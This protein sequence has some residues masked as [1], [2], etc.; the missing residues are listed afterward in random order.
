M[1]VSEASSS[2]STNPNPSMSSRSWRLRVV[3]GLTASLGGIAASG[4]QAHRLTGAELGVL[5]TVSTIAVVIAAVTAGGWLAE[6]TETS[7]GAVAFSRPAGML[8]TGLVWWWLA[9]GVTAVAVS[10][11]VSGGT[12]LAAAGFMSTDAQRTAPV[13]L[14]VMTDLQWA[15]PLALLTAIVVIVLRRSRHRRVVAIDDSTVENRGLGCLLWRLANAVT[16]VA[17]GLALVQGPVMIMVARQHRDAFVDAAVAEWDQ[18]LT[19][20][21][22]FGSAGW[23]WIWTIV[24]SAAIGLV[25][26]VGVRLLAGLGRREPPKVSWRLALGA[27]TATGLLIRIAAWVGAST[28][29][30]GGDAVYYHGAAN[31]IAAGRG[32]IDPLN[33]IE[34]GEAE[35]SAVHGPLFPVVLS[36]GSRLGA[37]TWWDHRM[38]ASL[39]GTLTVALVGVLAHRLLGPGIALGAAALAALY[40]NLWLIDAQLYPEGLFAALITALLIGIWR[41]RDDPRITTAIGCG[42]LLGL[43]ALTRGEALLLG[44]SLIAPWFLRHRTLPWRHRLFQTATVALAALVVLA[45][46]TIRNLVTFERPVLISTNADEV[47]VYANCD[48]TYQGDLIGYWLYECQDRIRRDRGDPPGDESERARA[49]RSI[50]FEYAS[51]NLERLPV[52]IAARI[53]RQWELFRPVQNAQLT[54]FEGRHQSAATVGVITYGAFVVLAVPGIWLWRR[55]KVAIGPVAAIAVMVTL[56]A[57]YAYGNVRFRAPM[58]PLLCILAA[59]GLAALVPVTLR[60]APDGMHIAASETRIEPGTYLDPNPHQIP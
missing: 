33:F 58:E 26:T 48:E 41:W 42:I 7:S 17:P 52:V 6:R 28:R 59:S 36:I 3:A 56:T 34:T 22:F 12:W 53:A 38:I 19:A 55:R 51:D 32:F 13:G 35:P 46:W 47:F 37:T 24:I 15:I 60:G 50:G 18:A 5:S 45:P 49:W 43:A 25:M 30:I 31:L 21:A 16:L 14:A 44:P 1:V 23:L 39:L 57:A 54:G 4:H 40:P 29:V 11:S 27:L 10:P 2:G 8:A 9:L 20:P